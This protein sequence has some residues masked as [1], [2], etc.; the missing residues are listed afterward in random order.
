[1]D[2]DTFYQ[3][4]FSRN[5]G[6]ITERE[7]QELRYARVAI[8]GMGGMGGVHAATLARTGIGKFHIADFDTFDV[9]NINR[10]YGAMHSTIGQ[11]KVQVMASI[12]KDINPDAQI[13]VFDTAIDEQNIDAF[14]HNVDIVID[15]LDVFAIQARRLILRKAR[16]QGIPVISAGPIGFSA[17]LV[18]FSP[19]GMDF[20]TFAGIH[21]A[22]PEQEIILHFLAAVGSQGSHLRYMDVKGVDPAT[23][24]APSLGLACQMAAGIAAV[25]ATCLILNKR[26]PRFAPWFAQFDPYARHYKYYYRWLGARNPLHQLRMKILKQKIPALSAT[27]G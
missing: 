8:P 15:A 17:T 3:R 24:A 2:L 9:H 25:E 22:M 11:P 12:I 10:Q 7:Q 20:D 19:T 6:L 13:N 14:L 4:A 27:Q 16:E 26:K 1:M 5:R 21:D 23:G 18:C